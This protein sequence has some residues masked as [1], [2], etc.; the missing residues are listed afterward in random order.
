MANRESWSSSKD[1]L[2][3]E[4]NSNLL[5]LYDSYV[6]NSVVPVEHS[7][8]HPYQLSLE[9]S[10]KTSNKK[11]AQKHMTTTQAISETQTGN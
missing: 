6:E 5:N 1:N 10:D 11:P 2:S 8:P 9:A 7:G 4:S 3:D